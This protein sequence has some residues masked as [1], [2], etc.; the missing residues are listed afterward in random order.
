[1]PSANGSTISVVV[2]GTRKLSGTLRI[3]MAGLKPPG[4]MV[5]DGIP[6]SNTT[7]LIDE[8]GNMTVWKNVT[9]AK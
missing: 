7:D 2:Y 6:T 8:I 5:V 1:M 9:I 4:G 3:R